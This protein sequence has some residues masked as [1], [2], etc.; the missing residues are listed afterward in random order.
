MLAARAL[1]AYFPESMCER[2][3]LNPELEPSAL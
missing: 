2:V 3:R 1:A